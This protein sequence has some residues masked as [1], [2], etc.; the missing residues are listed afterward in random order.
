MPTACDPC[1]GQ[2][3]ARFMLGSLTG[4]APHREEPSDANE[5]GPPREATTEGDEHDERSRADPAAGLRFGEPDGDRRRRGV[6]VFLYVHEDLLERHVDPFCRRLDD[7][8]IG[9]VG[10]EEIDVVAG[11][12]GLAQHDLGGVSHRQ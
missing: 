11:V 9:L 8:G 5:G 10:D 4:V 12:A 1:P 6:A 3:N 7:A 2:R